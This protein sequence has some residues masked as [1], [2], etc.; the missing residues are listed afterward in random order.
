MIAA[1]HL[2]VFRIEIRHSIRLKTT[3]EMEDTIAGGLC[4]SNCGTFAFTVTTF[5]LLRTPQL[6][7]DVHIE[8]A[9][10]SFV[11]VAILRKLIR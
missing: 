3:R 5:D 7:G 6:L 10:Y 9:L 11:V 1:E 4:A 2:K 8:E